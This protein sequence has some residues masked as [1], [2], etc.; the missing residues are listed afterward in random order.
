MQLEKCTS[1]WEVGKLGERTGW[2]QETGAA[3]PRMILVSLLP[4]SLVVESYLCRSS[5][6]VAKP[7]LLSH[8]NIL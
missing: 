3:R 8:Q 6:L 7:M 2:E 5:H 4:S 1:R